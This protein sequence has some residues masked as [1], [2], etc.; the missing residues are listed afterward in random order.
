MERYLRGIPAS[1]GTC[2]Q[3]EGMRRSS[4]NLGPKPAQ[5][6]STVVCIMIVVGNQAG[7]DG[8]HGGA[9]HYR[10]IGEVRG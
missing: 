10:Q 2:K 3:G 5:E 9:S 8:S 6:A 7:V 1:P 4:Q